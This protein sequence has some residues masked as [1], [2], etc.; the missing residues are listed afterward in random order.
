MCNPDGVV[1]G[2]YRTSLSGNDLN[3]QFHNPNKTVH[4]TVTAVKKLVA[5]I[6]ERFG[7]GESAL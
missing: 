5:K 1:A 4:P 2:N 3:R 7:Y 6:R